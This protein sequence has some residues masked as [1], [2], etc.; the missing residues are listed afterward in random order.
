MLHH[1]RAALV[2]SMLVATA[3]CGTAT[4]ERS[5]R[6]AEAPQGSVRGHAEDRQERKRATAD[7]EIGGLSYDNYEDAFK[8][9]WPKV[10]GCLES[11][12]R[13]VEWIGGEFEVVMRVSRRGSV[14]W[15]YVSESDLGDRDTERCV[16]DLIR[17]RSWPRPKS[18]DGIARKRFSMEPAVAARDMEPSRLGKSL[19]YARTKARRCV[20]GIDGE[21]HAT[22]YIDRKG[23]VLTAGVAP[24]NEAGESVADCVVDALKAARMVQVGRRMPAASKVTFAL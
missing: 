19:F 15:A 22:A 21:F 8:Q 12:A 20:E 6:G 14:K 11:G 5:A 1:A 7:S 3:A 24:P 17:D 16:L 4:T 2:L 13:R 9:L 18:G 23:Q 10:A